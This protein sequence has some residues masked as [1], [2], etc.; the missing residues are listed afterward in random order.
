MKKYIYVG[1]GNWI[2][3]K[4]GVGKLCVFFCY[5]WK[6]MRNLLDSD[7]YVMDSNERRE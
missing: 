7:G 3:G 5:M 6:R 2:Y 1:F 4:R